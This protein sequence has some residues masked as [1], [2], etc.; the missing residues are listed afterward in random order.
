MQIKLLCHACQH[1]YQLTDSYKFKITYIYYLLYDLFFTAVNLKERSSDGHC[2]SHHVSNAVTT[3]SGS[4]SRENFKAPSASSDKNVDPFNTGIKM[5]I[6]VH[7]I[8]DELEFPKRIQAGDFSEFYT[9]VSSALLN[10]KSGSKPC[11]LQ[12]QF[13]AKWYDFNEDTE[14]DDLCMDEDNPEIIIKATSS[15]VDSALLGS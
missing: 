10:K 4:A 15:P 14:F 6:K 7:L 11:H 2:N 12:Y 1:N 13:G 9:K 8:Y 3:S 5:N